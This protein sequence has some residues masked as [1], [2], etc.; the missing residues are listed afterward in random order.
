MRDKKRRNMVK[1][2]IGG[3]LK[4]GDEVLGAPI[5]RWRIGEQDK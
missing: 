4:G 1:R 5:K 2:G 3:K